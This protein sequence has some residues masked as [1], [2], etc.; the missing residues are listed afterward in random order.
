MKT[1]PKLII[2]VI[3]VIT[4]F[5]FADETSVTGRDSS[6]SQTSTLQISGTTTTPSL[7]VI[8]ITPAPRIILLFTGDINPGRCIAKASIIAAD[9]TYPFHFVG[10]KLRAADITIGSLDG[11]ISNQSPPQA[12]PDSTNLIGPEN[13]IHGLQFAGFDVI[14]VATNHIKD[15]GEKGYDCDDKAFLDTINNLTDAGIKPVGGGQNLSESR[16]PVVIEKQGIRFA[17]LGINQ[18]DERVWALENHPGT[19]P[20]SQNAIGQINT[21]IALARKIADVVIVLAQWGIEYASYPEEEQRTWAKSFLDAGA[22]IVVGNHPHIIQPVE[23]FPNGVAFYSLGN[24]VFD[25]GQSFRREG[26]AAEAVF[27][28]TQLESWR[29]HPLNINYYTYQPHWVEGPEAEKILKRATPL[30]Q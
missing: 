19:A 15:C 2:T 8:D 28:G 23:V 13:M 29:L 24:F 1:K 3:T 22:T 21:D 12:C 10:E 25:Q 27:A 20:L 18:I 11:T 26:I 14:T 4:M 7:P 16:L 5:V 30:S 9:F 6:P 17:F